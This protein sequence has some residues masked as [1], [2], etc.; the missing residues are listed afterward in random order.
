MLEIIEAKNLDE[1]TT[2]EKE[3]RDIM[4]EALKQQGYG[5]WLSNVEQHFKHNVIT[6][7]TL[8]MYG[9]KIYGTTGLQKMSAFTQELENCWISSH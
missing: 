6:D 1:K 3:Q 4:I 2:T 5:Q 7:D 8:Q 9:N